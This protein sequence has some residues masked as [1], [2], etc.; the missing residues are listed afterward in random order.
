MIFFSA[1]RNKTICVNSFMKTQRVNPWIALIFGVLA[2][3]LLFKLVGFV[4][5]LLTYAAPI[6]LIAA[7]IIKP[8]AVTDYIKWLVSMTKKNVLTGVVFIVLSLVAFPF[9]SAYLLFKAINYD[10][11]ENIK[12]KMSAQRMEYQREYQDNDF[13]DFEILEETP[14]E[15]PQKQKVKED[16][17]YDGLFE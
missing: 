14:L 11:F 15:L 4:F 2:L 17:S 10:R 13:T 1:K 3:Y 16:N 12:S 7:L 6:M 8:K 5:R 9:T